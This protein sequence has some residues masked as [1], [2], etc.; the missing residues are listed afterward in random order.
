MAVFSK[1]VDLI[2]ESPY[3]YKRTQ[4]ILYNIP[5]CTD[6]HMTAERIG[7]SFEHREPGKE[8]SCNYG[9]G[10]DG[11]IIGIADE[12]KRS[13][14]TSSAWADQRGITFEIS[15]E[16]GKPHK[17]DPLAFEAWK[18]L[19]VE[20]MIRYNKDTLLY[21]PDAAQAKAYKV[22]E[23]EMVILLHRWFK[24]KA[25]PGDWMVEQLP[26]AVAE[27]NARVKQAKQGA[28]EAPQ[29]P[30]ADA[31][32]PEEYTVKPGDRL[33]KI[34]QLYGFTADEL[35]AYNGI[36]DKNKI[37]IGQIIKIP[38]KTKK[39]TVTY[40]TLPE[41]FEASAAGKKDFEIREDD[42]EIAEGDT[43]ILKEYDGTN[44]TGRTLERK[45]KYILRNVPEYG[46][47]EGFVII[48]FET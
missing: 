30:A 9:C 29:E 32:K 33:S 41:Y 4:P 1:L 37:Y 18:R 34:G 24:N 20:I 8:A 23:N 28:T 14:C 36:P 17:M 22:K 21:I 10:S 39:E 6:A 44:Y 12:T 3:F 42:K 45:I 2:K 11:L 26:A 46:L 47:K 48:G 25:C 19:S 27:I 15:S 5:H 16:H 38:P 35:A 31:G 13:W 43:V 40:K 7:K